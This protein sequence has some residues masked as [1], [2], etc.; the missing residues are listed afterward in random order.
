[1]KDIEGYASFHSVRSGRRSG[2]VSVY[3]KK[4]FNSQIISQFTYVNETIEICSVKIEFSKFKLFTIAIYRPHSGSK[5]EF[6]STLESI[7]N[8]P[9]L[10]N[11]TSYGPK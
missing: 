7:L 2:G 4:S 8:S 6:V 11:S 9:F 5:E 1:M 3:V 10:R